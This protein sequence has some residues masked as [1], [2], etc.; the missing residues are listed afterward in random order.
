MARTSSRPKKP[1]Q[2]ARSTPSE[3]APGVFV[4]GWK[5]AVAFEGQRFC[6]LDE[7]PTDEPL[8]A[9]GH[10]PIYDETKDQAIRPNLDRLAKMMAA[11]HAKS[12]PVLVFCGHGIRRASLGGA[13]YLHVAEGIPLAEAYDRVRA[14]RPQIETAAEWIGNVE[15][16]G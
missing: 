3:I 7:V 6:V 9:E 1:S 2:P 10:V 4:G 15:N 16:L 8:P 11:A 13:W 14:V 12:G 5:D